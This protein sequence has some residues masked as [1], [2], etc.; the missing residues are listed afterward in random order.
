MV[1]NSR[2][3]LERAC[4]KREAVFEEIYYHQAIKEAGGTA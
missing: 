4:W 1:E 3:I 2:G